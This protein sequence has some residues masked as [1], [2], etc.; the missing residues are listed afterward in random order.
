[1][2]QLEKAKN[3]IIKLFKEKLD[4]AYTYHNWDHTNLVLD[5]INAIT[6]T[7][8]VS[9]DELLTLQM[10]ALFHDSGYISGA[11]NHEDESQ[12]ISKAYLSENGFDDTFIENVNLCIAATRMGQNSERPLANIL[13]DADMCGLGNKKYQAITE[14]LRKELNNTTEKNINKKKLC[15]VTYH[16]PAAQQLY[17]KQKTKNLKV[18]LN[19]KAKRKK[20][21]TKLELTI[22]ENKSAQTQFKTALRNHIALS[23][24][25]DNKANIMISVNALILTLALPFLIDKAMDNQHFWFPTMLLAMVCLVSMI[26]ATLATR[27]IKLK[28]VTTMDEVKNNASNL[29]FFGNYYKMKYEDYKNGV[30]HV[31]SDT[32][33]LDDSIIRDLFFL[34]KSL[35][36]KFSHLRLCYSIFMYGISTTVFT[37]LI[38]YFY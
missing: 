24:I 27:P 3:Y 31:L 18:L 36:G 22:A 12:K 14:T 32:K 17:D 4:T 33:T 29:F 28:G 38:V 37:F 13:Q 35:G 25:A 19:K 30:S 1:M 2:E 15:D 9:E 8:E 6:D 7:M 5:S 11:L 34:G 16:T 23:N 21:P 26:F 20:K 10:A